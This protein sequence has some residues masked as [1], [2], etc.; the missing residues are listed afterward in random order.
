MLC[1]INLSTRTFTPLIYRLENLK[2]LEKL[3]TW[4]IFQCYFYNICYWSC[5]L[6]KM[7]H[8]F[9]IFFRIKLSISFFNKTQKNNF[10]IIS[11][12]FDKYRPY[13]AN[14]KSLY[15][16]KNKPYNFYIPNHVACTWRVN[17]GQLT[18]GLLPV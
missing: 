4:K 2:P 10:S 3:S 16:V 14:P 17:F 15:F 8:S 18:L 13:Y 5:C 12:M 9:P 6:K 11:L 7:I 1:T